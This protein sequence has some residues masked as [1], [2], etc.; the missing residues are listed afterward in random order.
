MGGEVVGAL[1]AMV[2]MLLSNNNYRLVFALSLVPALMAIGVL[3]WGVRPNPASHPRNRTKSPYQRIRLESLKEF[4]PAFWWLLV[5][6]FFLYLARF[7]EAFLS[8]KAKD[9]GWSVAYLPVLFILDNFIQALVALPAG[10]YA[11]KISRRL[12]LGA[13]VVLMVAAQAT[14][15]Y[16]SSIFGVVLGIILVGLHMG[17]TQGLIKALIA[18]ATPPE[19]R[20]TAFSSFFVV[21]GFAIFL[22]NTIA[23]HISQQFGLSAT[24]VAGGFFTLISGAILYFAFY[25]QKQVIPRTPLSTTQSS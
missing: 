8:L 2:I 14:L 12:M 15:S 18:Q 25:K 16:A 22:A 23:G 6:F 24:F 3:L 5:A 1:L 17:A 13:G 4:S 9:V 19:L 11:D 7:S 10:R 21:G 20:G